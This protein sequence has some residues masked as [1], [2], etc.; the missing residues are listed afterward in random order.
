MRTPLVGDSPP[1]GRE[2]RVC[3][4][5]VDE[6]IRIATH[7]S[8][9]AMGNA[10]V[11]ADRNEDDGFKRVKSPLFET[12]DRNAFSSVLRFSGAYFLY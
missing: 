10:R 12:K 9:V 11:E 2:G 3:A 8:V 1:K 6:I 7:K 4:V 5:A